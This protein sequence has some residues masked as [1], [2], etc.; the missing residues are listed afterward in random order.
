MKPFTLAAALVIVTTLIGVPDA[1]PP[2]VLTVT[3]PWLAPASPA[4][5]EA[6]LI[7]AVHPAGSP[8]T[9]IEGRVRTPDAVR[10]A[11]A[12]VAL[13]RPGDGSRPGGE[14]PARL[15]AVVRSDAAGRFRFL[16]V[17]P[18]VHHVVVSATGFA[19]GRA[20]L[21]ANAG[22][23]RFV[24]VA[25]GDASAA[26]DV[27][28]QVQDLAGRPLIGALVRADRP[29]A[30][31]AVAVTDHEGRFQLAIEPGQHAFSASAAGHASQRRFLQLVGRQTLSLRLFATARIAGTVSGP[32]PG[33]D[34]AAGGGASRAMAGALVRLAAAE[35]EARQ[36]EVL[37]DQAGRFAFVD[38]EPGRYV[39]S[40]QHGDLV[41][42]HLQ[43]L[44]VALGET[45]PEIG[46]RLQP[47]ARLGGRI[48]GP[49]G[50][51]VA[52]AQVQLEPSRPTDLG[53]GAGRATALSDA[54][55][56][57]LLAGVLAGRYRV[58]VEAAPLAPAER[59]EVA[60]L[61]REVGPLNFRLEAGARLRGQVTDA[62]GRPLV[63]A[64]LRAAV[65]SDPASPRLVAAGSSRS[66][67]DGSYELTGLPAGKLRLS[68]QHP[69]Q[70]ELDLNVD[71]TP[72][73][74]VQ[75][76]MRFAA[77]AFVR[78]RV[79]FH[80]G[81]PA[82]GARVRWLP[83]TRSAQE[84]GGGGSAVAVNPDGSYR[85][86]PVQAS[87][88][89]I[90]AELAGDPLLVNPRAGG[91][92][93]RGRQ[94]R[95]SLELGAGQIKG[96]VDLTLLRD[97]Q[98]ISGQLLDPHRSPVA[99]ALVWAS[100]IPG[101]DWHEPDGG[102]PRAVSDQAGRFLLTGLPAGEY[103]VRAS[104]VRYPLARRPGV[105]AGAE[106]VEVAFVAPAFVS[107]RVLDGSAA[108]VAP[109]RVQV[110]EALAPGVAFQGQSLGR[111]NLHWLFQASDGGF[112]IGPLAPGEY[113]LRVRGATGESALVSGIKLR[114][115][116]W[117]KDLTVTI[118]AGTT[119]L[120]AAA[121]DPMS[122][123]TRTRP[124]PAAR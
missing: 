107:G 34:A 73:G 24:E 101:G 115:G 16:D 87:A 11:G 28:G 110:H 113:H 106:G 38:L 48:V 84:A 114:A 5:P 20:E 74:L 46:L 111:E 62:Q 43:P 29:G 19:P 23:P 8:V 61:G 10:V 97:D 17:Q 44:A 83:Q 117:R 102:R 119:L 22:S 25:L 66:G 118:G 90:Q 36:W 52:G 32:G 4:R 121:A 9:M 60:V 33:G 37:A 42:F 76:P 72:A 35:P 26:A 1:R 59:R 96:G 45:A 71:V 75:L 18:G 68:V 105:I 116:E 12:L 122:L 53:F 50:Q 81:G 98:T 47:A 69:Q 65:Q 7:L 63:G 56:R 86:G 41:G 94:Q 80:D 99:G 123:R 55:G 39:L 92:F 70:G 78:G 93:G 30:G 103:E 77:P 54:D 89:R 13:S 14:G 31:S 6:G 21:R 3:M 57:Y 27:A 108:P 85:L 15:E 91:G 124:L 51:A 95:A 79:R 100:V 64:G 120:D 104:H 82:G 49:D 88:G 40:A 109:V 2:R 58:R 67:T 112:S